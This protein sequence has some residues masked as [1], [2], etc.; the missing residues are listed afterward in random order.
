MLKD[1]GGYIDTSEI[2]A[3][4]AGIK[5]VA[6]AQL[7]SDKISKLWD[8]DGDGKVLRAQ[9]PRVQYC[10]HAMIPPVCS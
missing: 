1:S 3:A 5:G 8:A 6:A 9:P 2:L 4:I 10:V 7:N